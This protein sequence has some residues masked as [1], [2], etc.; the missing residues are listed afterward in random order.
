MNRKAPPQNYKQQHASGPLPRALRT[1]MTGL[2]I[3]LCNENFTFYSHSPL[4]TNS[5]KSA[6]VSSTLTISIAAYL[7]QSNA[8][9]E[10]HHRK[11]FAHKSFFERPALSHIPAPIRLRARSPASKLLLRRSI[12]RHLSNVTDPSENPIVI[13]AIQAI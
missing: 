3:L 11:S 8:I 13:I 9:R 4:R 12:L 6:Q 1:S 5:Q 10:L 2:N 7:L